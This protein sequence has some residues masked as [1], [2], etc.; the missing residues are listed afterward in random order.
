[1]ALHGGEG[2]YDKARTL[3]E[4]QRM[5]TSLIELIAATTVFVTSHIVLAG[6]P[7]RDRFVAMLGERGFRVAYS[8]LSIALIVWMAMAYNAAPWVEIWPATTGLR[9]LTLGVT[10]IAFIFVVAG[11]VTPNPSATGSDSRAVVANGPSG[12][13]KITRHPV[14]WGVALWG[15]VHALARGDAAAVIFFGG[16][17]VLAL[18][19]AWALDTKKAAQLG[20]AWED[21]RGRTS[22]WPFAALIAGRSRVTLREIGWWRIGLGGAAFVV[23]LILHPLLFGADPWPL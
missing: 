16:F 9:H 20:D 4:E 12:I 14:M 2:C 7:V 6:S 10:L 23:F 5:Q 21:Y 17:T 13:Q 22:F 3:V 1:M 8:L 18:V 11:I 15:I 19:G